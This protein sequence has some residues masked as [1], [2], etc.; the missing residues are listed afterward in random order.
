MFKKIILIL[1]S[2]LLLSVSAY[3]GYSFYRDYQT[4]KNQ[5]TT[6]NPFE[7][8]TFPEPDIVT[9]CEEFETKEFAFYL[10]EK[11]EFELNNKFGLYIYAERQDFFEKAS[12]LVNS[13]GGSWGYVLI[14]YN[15]KDRD[16]ARWKRVFEDLRR[17]K[18]I[19]VIQLW[20]IDTSKYEKQT[21]QAAKFLNS[22][23]WPI[24]PRYISA[25]NEMNDKRFWYGR[26]D[27]KEYARILDFTIEAFKDEN[28][29]FKIMNGAFNISAS[30]TH[31]TVDAFYY[32]QKMNEEVPGIFNKLDAWASHSY[33]QPNF[34]GSPLAKG[35]WSIRA[36]E[37]EL[38]FLYKNLGVKK[39][40]PVFITETGWAHREGLKEDK[41][42]LTEEQVAENYKIAFEQVWLKDK[43]VRAVMPFTIK[44]N[45][46]FDHFSW[47]KEDYK[48]TYKQ[49]D[50][51][52]SLSKVQGQPPELIKGSIK[53]PNCAI[54]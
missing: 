41:S 39:E 6:Y 24:R 54:N 12:E 33:P 48:S 37:D 36:Y 43:R 40:L 16:S 7:N 8:I 47:I 49:F 35:R 17:L 34:T 19:P 30:N 53:I 22:F 26:I 15:V 29:N 3:L 31:E 46:P 11:D 38:N 13:N 20:D 51:V 10:D 25:Y 4:K 2:T 45:P 52:K 27:P 18:L 32:M 14:P 50:T 21:K 44:Y 23:D 28:E 9:E 5:T 1:F 42:F